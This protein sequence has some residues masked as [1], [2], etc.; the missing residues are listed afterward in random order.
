[1]HFVKTEDAGNLT[2]SE[3]TKPTH[4]EYILSRLCSQGQAGS[5]KLVYIVSLEKKSRV[6]NK[7]PV[8]F[9]T[10]MIFILNKINIA[11]G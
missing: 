3:F 4:I 9:T 2:Y 8:F 6:A 10:A 5:R 1:M 7:I 11:L